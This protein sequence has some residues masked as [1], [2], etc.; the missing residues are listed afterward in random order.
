MRENVN[1][2]QNFNVNWLIF[3]LESWVKGESAKQK[4]RVFAESSAYK[5]D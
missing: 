1:C 5:G 3:L 4:F 2:D